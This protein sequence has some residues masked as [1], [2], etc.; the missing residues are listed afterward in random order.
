MEAEEADVPT[1]QD[2]VGAHDAEDEAYDEQA[3]QFEAAYNFRF[4]VSIL[5]IPLMLIILLCITL[6]A[7][8]DVET[9]ALARSHNCTLLS[10]HSQEQQHS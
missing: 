1:Y 8:T 10:L 4:E 2:I 6:H 7:K 3:D 5:L 9:V